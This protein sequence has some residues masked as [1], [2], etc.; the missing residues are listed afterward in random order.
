MNRTL[1][2]LVAAAAA[3]LCLAGCA[4]NP[5][6]GTKD[7][8]VID[9]GQELALGDDYHPD[10]IMMY[11]GE[12]QDPELKRY[13][14]TIVL[15]L[16]AVSHRRKMPIDFTVLN[17]S[18]INAFA[19]P[20]HVYA[21]RGFLAKLE[22]EAQFASVMGH[23]WAHVTARHTAKQMSQ[24]LAT[25]L[26]L[27]VG[28][29]LAG[30]GAVAQVATTVTGVGVTLLGL[31]YSRGQ[32]HQAD[33]VGTYY[34]A[35]AGWDPVQSIRMQEILGELGH[36]S[37]SVLDKYLSTHPQTQS[38]IQDIQAVIREKGLASR[39]VQGD[40]IY[41]ERWSRRLADLRE[42]DASFE[43]YD[44]GSKALADDRYQ[45]ALAL[46]EKAIA[47]RS[48]QPQFHR[49]KADALGALG[50]LDEADAAYRRS[51]AIY[52]RYVPAVVGMARVDMARKDYAAAEQQFA[53]AARDWPGSLN[54][55][56]GLG[57]A[58]YNQGK[59]KAAIDPLAGVA[60]A[61]QNQPQVWYALA[62]CYDRTGQAANAA[63][64]YSNA[65]QTGLSGADARQARSR[66]DALR[67]ALPRR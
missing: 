57:L 25:N 53:R 50:R 29:S 38:R 7:F 49:L 23:E 22:N 43:P 37:D 64:A 5:V 31:S 11:D 41:A 62:V 26:A 2:T 33:R 16:R 59:F 58:R 19:I 28:S 12:L 8:V 46:A 55:R 10:I 45:D 60:Q 9:A 66:L 21:T 24:S 36:R 35:L 48:D 18:V 39:Y 42:L 51:L 67:A 34:M 54:A 17:T 4:V 27:G 47:G 20:G 44:D 52:P 13:L 1:H 65:L 14:G 56:Y 61:V 63:V 30:D 15:R 40:G 3:A 32:E 6:S